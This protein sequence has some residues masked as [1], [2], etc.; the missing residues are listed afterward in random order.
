[1]GCKTEKQILLKKKSLKI[2]I[3]RKKLENRKILDVLTLN[4]M[5]FLLPLYDQVKRSTN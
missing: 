3:G 4:Q 1:M 5:F 2:F